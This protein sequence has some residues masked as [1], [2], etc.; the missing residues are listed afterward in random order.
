[1][2]PPPLCN[3]CDFV[4]QFHFVSAHIL[5]KRK[6]AADFFSRFEAD[7]NETMI[8]KKGKKLFTKPIRVNIE[9]TGIS[10]EESVINTDDDLIEPPEQDI[11]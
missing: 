5:G 10:S 3:A 8:L 9:W 4:L 1:M 11:W 6:T 7:P 2:I